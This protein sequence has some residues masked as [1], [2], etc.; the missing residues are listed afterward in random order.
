MIELFE[1]GLIGGTFDRFHKGHISLINQSLRYCKKLEIWITSDTIANIKDPRIK[2]WEERHEEILTYVENNFPSRV[3][4]GKLEDSFGPA[5][6]HDSAEVIFCTE[7]NI[8]NCEEINVKRLQNSLPKLSIVELELENAWDKK[9]ISSSRIRIGEI[10][11]NGNNCHPGEVLRSPMIITKKAEGKLKNPYGDLITGPENNI[12]IAMEQVK[13]K[14]SNS[15]GPIICVGDVTVLGAQLV[16]IPI[17]IALIDG[18]TKRRDWKDSRNIDNSKFSITLSCTNPPGQLTPSLLQSS[19]KAVFSWIRDSTSTL[20]E[21]DGE[22]D[23]A[24]LILHLLSP[25][26]GIILYGQPGKGVVIRVVT[27]ESKNHCQLIISYF[28]SLKI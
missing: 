23:L 25:L 28:E 21:V 27:E 8:R 5:P 26:G 1:L 24:P 7:D 18:K 2:T 22:E 19:E 13:R 10:D 11:R 12:S 15:I 4:F 3:I 16:N 6:T 9:P 14:I 17:D 20:I